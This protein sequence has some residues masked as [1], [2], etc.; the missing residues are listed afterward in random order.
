MKKIFIVIIIGILCLST[1]EILVPRGETN[2]TTGTTLAVNAFDESG[3]PPA[4]SIGFQAIIGLKMRIYDSGNNLVTSGQTGENGSVTFSLNPGIYSITYGG[5]LA[6]KVGEPI[7]AAR[8]FLPDT[9]QVTIVSGS[10]E[11]NLYAADLFYHVYAAPGDGGDPFQLDYLDLNSTTLGYEYSLTVTPGQTVDAIASFWELETINVPVWYLSAFGDWQPTVPLAELASGV[12]SPN[13]HNLYT[14]PFTFTAPT[15]AGTY[16]IRLN[17]VLDYDWPNSYYTGCHPNPS[18]G[19]DMCPTIISNITIDTATNDTTGTYSVGTITVT[20][21]SPTVSISAQYS[22]FVSAFNNYKQIFGQN[23]SIGQTV[24]RALSGAINDPP[25]H[26][27][28]YSWAGQTYPGGPDGFSI[29][30]ETIQPDYVYKIIG[31][32]YMGGSQPSASGWIK[33]NLPFKI[34]QINHACNYTW[35]NGSNV[36]LFVNNDTGDITFSAKWYNYPALIDA[37]AFEFAI[38]IAKPGGTLPPFS[39][40]TTRELASYAY[41]TDSGLVVMFGGTTW[42]SKDLRSDVWTFDLSTSQWTSVAA[43]TGPSER[44][45]A[46]MSYNPVAK[47]LIVFGGCNISGEVSDTWTFQFTGSNTG[48][49]TQIPASG[50]SARSGAPMVFDSKNNLFVL[51]GGE[52]YVYSLDETWVFYPSNNTWSNRNPSPSPSQRAR[53]A[54]AYDAKSGKVLL[55]GGLDKG[56]G[57]LLNDTWLYDAATNTWQQVAT[58]TAPSARQ[59]PSLACDGNGVFYLFGGWRVDAGGGLGQYLNDTWKFNMTTMQWTQ[60]SPS[61]SPPAQSQGALLHIGSDKFVLINGWRDSSLGDVWCYN[62]TQNTWSSQIYHSVS[63]SESGLAQGTTWSV[64]FNGET[65]SSISNSITFNA[66]NGVYPFSVTPIGAS[67]ASSGLINVEGDT[68]VALVWGSQPLHVFIKEIGLP[69]ST[70][71]SVTYGPV[72]Q[73]STSDTINFTFY[74]QGAYRLSMSS[75]GYTAEPSPTDVLAGATT[76]V[77]FVPNSNLFHYASWDPVRNSYSIQNPS[78]TWSAGGN[79]YGFS[80]TALLYFMRYTMCNNTYPYFP[81]QSAHQATSTSDLDLGNTWATLNNASLAVMFHQ[82]YDP[83]GGISNFEKLTNDKAQNFKNLNS[84][85]QKGIPLVIGMWNSTGFFHAVIAWGVG[86]LGNGTYAIAIYDPNYPQTT[87]VAFYTTSSNVFSYSATGPFDNFVVRNPYVISTSWSTLWWY[88]INQTSW[89]FHNW[90]NFTVAGYNI[91]IADKNVTIRSNGLIDKFTEMGNSQAFVKT[92]SKSSGIEEGN[93][94]VY[95]IPA[96]TPFTVS[97]PSSSQSTILVT[98]VNN[99]SGQLV[100]YGYFLNASTMQ[101]SLDYTLT[102]SNSSLLISSGANAL[103]I[104]TT[105]FYATSQNHSIFQASNIQLGSMHTANFTVNNWQTLNNT[106]SAPVTWTISPTV[107]E[108][109]PML[110]LPLFMIATLIAV[111]LFKR[112]RNVKK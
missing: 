47:N 2:T 42:N 97:D 88:E 53:A 40:D 72:T 99:E 104:S 52:R 11:V 29:R 98:R 19:R 8:P 9:K 46:S 44:F 12:A 92:I 77:I 34:E 110:I 24:N 37:G 100:G 21:E 80:S 75:P 91:V 55:F 76:N 13:S 18:L 65:K 107:P 28:W 111:M 41:D 60:L 15:Q 87:Q 70:E 63:F 39:Y 1:L 96:G 71:W 105:I 30:I 84:S 20:G 94:Q 103:N 43:G 62:E 14:V 51:F 57:S 93:V 50:P 33:V 81:S 68:N 66:V 6:R 61:T 112:K 54:M 32:G 109:S 38:T 78:T 74:D 86:K 67:P 49:W 95:A 10:N 102:P 56:V 106:S 59:W 17:G 58:P 82:V 101:G 16:H 36:R 85:L 26:Y 4:S 25:A 45:G 3:F 73:T 27:S 31:L 35:S 48:T 22:S 69:T 5:C 64:T 108:F 7:T 23:V 89:W 79:C 83:N 90:L